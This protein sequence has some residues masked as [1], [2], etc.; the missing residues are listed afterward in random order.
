MSIIDD[1]S[2][3]VWIYVLKEK[4]E[5]FDK[6]KIWCKAV[7]VEKGYSLKCLRTDNGME[8]LSSEFDNFYKERGLRD[9]GPHLGIR[10]NM[11][12]QSE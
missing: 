9:I 2:R 1:Y 6:F 5:T 8:F 3:K 4:S 11:G 7:E 10:N 12:Q